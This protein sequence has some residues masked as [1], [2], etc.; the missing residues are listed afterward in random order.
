[1]RFLPFER[2][3]KSINQFISWILLLRDNS[4]VSLPVKV[5]TKLLNHRKIQQL[6]NNDSLGPDFYEL[7]KSG[8][9]RDRMKK[10]N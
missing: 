8:W 5:N 7:A 6:S 2:Y 3:S 10:K 4:A 1:M 9:S